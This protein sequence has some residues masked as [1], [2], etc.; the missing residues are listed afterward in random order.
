MRAILFAFFVSGCGATSEQPPG[1]A[2]ADADS[3]SDSD[4][5][6]DA[7][8]AA[9]DTVCPETRPHLGAL[10]AGDLACTFTDDEG[11]WEYGCHGGLWRIDDAYDCA[12][13][14][15]CVPELT[16][17][18]DAPFS[19]VLEGATI[20]VGPPSGTEA[21]RPFA[22]DDQVSLLWGSQGSPMI[23]VRIRVTGVDVADLPDC[24]FARF[25]LTGPNGDGEPTVDRMALHCGE[26][27]SLLAIVPDTGLDLGCMEAP[28]TLPLDVTVEIQGVGQ[29]TVPVTV[30]YGEYEYCYG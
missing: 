11:T 26:S 28:G 10:C 23:E 17:S 8:C 24:V 25:T 21:F 3:D 15:G 18:C 29:T 14:G 7:D 6:S 16:E 20:E 19:G 9:R 30:A 12:S 4:A 22:P 1:D 27:L 5:D 2:D 13:R